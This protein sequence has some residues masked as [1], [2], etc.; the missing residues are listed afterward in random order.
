[1]ELALWE[2]LPNILR[3]DSTER[4]ARDPQALAAG[5]GAQAGRGLPARGPTSRLDPKAVARLQQPA[6]REPRRSGH[7]PAQ[8][9]RRIDGNRKFLYLSSPIY[10]RPS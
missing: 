10:E 4:E 1:M 9:L 8:R 3:L 5:V 2:R 7:R 6:H